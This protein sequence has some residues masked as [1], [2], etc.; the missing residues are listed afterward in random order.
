MSMIRICLSAALFAPAA[1]A[2]AQT[3]ADL[4]QSY[5]MYT[6]KEGD[7][8]GVDSGTSPRRFMVW[9]DC[10]YAAAA[11]GVVVDLGFDRICPGARVKAPKDCKVTKVDS[12]TEKLEIDLKGKMVMRRSGAPPSLR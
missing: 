9:L 7:R 3:C 6:Y 11:E 12:T 1:P 5:T 4:G 8:V 10:K 2:A